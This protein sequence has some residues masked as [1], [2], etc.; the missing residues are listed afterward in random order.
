MIN[1]KPTELTTAEKIIASKIARIA[2][3]EAEVMAL[4]EK[5]AEVQSRPMNNRP[6]WL[7]EL[8]SHWLTLPDLTGGIDRFSQYPISGD[9][10]V[11]SN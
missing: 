10:S 3:L 4:K 9:P 2:M 7:W 5:L 8:E 6:N 11:K 1:I